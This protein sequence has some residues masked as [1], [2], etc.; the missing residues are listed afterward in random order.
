MA[1]QSAT[2]RARQPIVSSVRDRNTMPRLSMRP[3]LDF[4]RYRE[5]VGDRFIERAVTD[6][7]MDALRALSGQDYVDEYASKFKDKG[8]Q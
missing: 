3:S 8:K 4:N 7:V 6:E 5:L 2:E 1:A